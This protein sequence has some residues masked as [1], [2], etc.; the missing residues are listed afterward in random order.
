MHPL[1]LRL[2]FVICALFS[3][4]ISQV[5]AW[6]PPARQH[7]EYGPLHCHDSTFVPDHVLRLTYEDVP[8]G[9]QTRPSVLVNG[10]LPGPELRL[11]PG[12]TSWIRVYNDMADYN[13]TMVRSYMVFIGVYADEC[14]TGMV[15]PMPL[16]YPAVSLPLNVSKVRLLGICGVYKDSSR[17]C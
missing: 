11:L 17:Q 5:I 8:I 12:R 14:S 1:Q 15:R 4:H 16:H 3:S 7:D 6:G 9:C 2:L 10:S 13:A